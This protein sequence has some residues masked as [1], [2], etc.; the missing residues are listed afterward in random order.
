MWLAAGRTGCRDALRTV[1]PARAWSVTVADSRSR[2]C[3]TG[4]LMDVPN[5]LRATSDALL[6]DLEA[7][8]VLEEEKRSL[9]L[10]DPRL[11]EIAEQV[12]VIA[13]RVLAGTQR[14]TV[15]SQAAADEPADGTSIGDVRRPLAA[16]LA[17][18]R[19]VERRGAAA[20]EGS[21]EAAEIEVLTAR[22]RE[23]YREAYSQREP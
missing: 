18:W 16:I 19:E 13:A 17:E 22:L 7:L 3:K 5:D 8:T 15:L 11:L 1:A 9:P 10:D 4:D 21:A 6:R 12:E 20:P 14:Q 23:E 2:T